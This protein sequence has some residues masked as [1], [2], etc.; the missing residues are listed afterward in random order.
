MKKIT[1]LIIVLFSYVFVYSEL[2][3]QLQSEFGFGGIGELQYSNGKMFTSNSYGYTI[4][5]IQGNGT[6]QSV[7]NVRYSPHINPHYSHDKLA[8]YSGLMNFSKREDY[9]SYFK[10]GRASC[11]ERV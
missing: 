6:L 5:E 10:I 9:G 2:D 7:G 1:I 11:R 8:V 4:Y 3:Y